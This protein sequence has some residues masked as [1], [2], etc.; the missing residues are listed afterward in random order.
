MS[1]PAG[2]R[3]KNKLIPKLDCGNIISSLML[4]V[5]RAVVL[6][7]RS[8]SQISQLSAGCSC[9]RPHSIPEIGHSSKDYHN[10]VG[11]ASAQSHLASS[12]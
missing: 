7:R 12:L 8:W 3:K 1:L 2:N 5:H 9:L 11:S 4:L 6:T 10:I